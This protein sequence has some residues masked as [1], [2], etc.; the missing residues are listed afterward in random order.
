MS[1]PRLHT[2]LTELFGIRHPILAGGLMWLSD[3]TYVAAVVNA[4]GMAFMTPRSFNGLEAFREQLRRCAEL[5]GGR[6]FGVNLTLSH[7]LG[8]NAQVPAQLAMALAEGVRCFETV[9][10]SPGPLF[11][12]IHAGGGRV[13]HKASFVA[14]ALKAE[15]QGADAVALVGMEAG[16][17][18]GLH[19]LPATLLGAEALQTLKVPLAIGGG[20]GSGR[21]VAA[22]L[23]LGADAVVIGTRFLVSEE[24]WAHRRYKEHLLSR[25]SADSVV[26]MRSV[27][28]P[29]RVL[30]NT[31]AREVRA[32]EAAGARRH[33][34]FGE[35]ALG[36]Y[37]RDH[38]YV[39]GDWERGML[40]MGPGI[41]FADRIEPVAA[42]IER[43]MADT[44]AACRRLAG[45]QQR[46]SAVLSTEP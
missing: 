30:D 21:Q 13:I 32:L 12:A 8:A 10:P 25:G 34:D 5:T 42:I 9:G 7:R 36:R 19:E 41:A 14:H 16:G 27:G 2:R 31:T 33:E 22:A 46:A 29:W 3:A 38:A 28:S 23:A 35:L 26:G 1:E 4:G 15:G 11:D 44:L 20:I 6:P 40:S 43:L 37:G 18:P 39:A 24:I 17:H 45:L